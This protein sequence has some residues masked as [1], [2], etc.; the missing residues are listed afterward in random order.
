PAVIKWA[1][2][3]ELYG[4]LRSAELHVYFYCRDWEVEDAAAIVEASVDTAAERDAGR[5]CP[6]LELV[7]L[8][9]H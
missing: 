8:E 3:K 7:D 5:D 2:Y 1:L 9:M 4:L 6:W